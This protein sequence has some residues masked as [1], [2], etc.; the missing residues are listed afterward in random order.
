MFSN[1]NDI[2]Y[3][4]SIPAINNFWL[5]LFVNNIFLSLILSILCMW[6]MMMAGCMV[7]LQSAPHSSSMNS[8]FTHTLNTGATKHFSVI[9]MVAPH[10]DHIW[11]YTLYIWYG[12]ARAI[13]RR[14]QQQIP[15]LSIFRCL[16]CHSDRRILGPRVVRP[17][18]VLFL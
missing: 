11:S 15:F 10:T 9:C 12:A 8:T 14:Q 3:F 18:S 5:V 4:R 1:T 16:Y 2:S 7:N 6:V 17:F 13:M